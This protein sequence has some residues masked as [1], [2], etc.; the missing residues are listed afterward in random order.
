MH[1]HAAVSKDGGTFGICGYPSRRVAQERD[2]PQDEA[3]VVAHA[4]HYT[5]HAGTRPTGLAMRPSG[6]LRALMRL[7]SSSVSEKS[8]TARFSA[9]RAGFDERGI[10]TTIPFWISQRSAT[11]AMVL[12]F[13]RAISPSTGSLN[14]RPRPSGQ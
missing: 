4:D 9:I 14:R 1:L 7:T 6:R 5:S 3:S 12:P 10:G 8:S 2:A 13:W 11:W